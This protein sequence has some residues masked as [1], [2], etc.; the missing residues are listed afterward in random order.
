MMNSLYQVNAIGKHKK[1]YVIAVSAEQ[2]IASAYGHWLRENIKNV[3]EFQPDFDAKV[4]DLDDFD[5]PT[6]LSVMEDD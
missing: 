2:A 3:N 5:A 4:V 1:Y 6:I